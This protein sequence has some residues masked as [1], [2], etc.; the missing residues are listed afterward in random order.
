LAKAP[1]AVKALTTVA[2]RRKCD[3][4]SSTWWATA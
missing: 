3:T 2:R 4:R 1:V